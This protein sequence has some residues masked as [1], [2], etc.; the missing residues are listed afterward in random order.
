VNSLNGRETADEQRAQVRGLDAPGTAADELRSQVRDLESAATAAAA[1]RRME[2]PLVDPGE[3]AKNRV[4]TLLVDYQTRL[5]YGHDTIG[6]QARLAEAISVMTEDDQAKARERGKEIRK[7]PAAERKPLWPDHVNRDDLAATVRAYAALAPVV[8]SR[9]LS[10]E[11]T[12]VDAT[13]AEAQKD[14]ATAM[15]AQIDRAIKSGKGLHDLE[16]DQLRA[17]IVDIEAG[18]TAVPDLLLADD[19]SAAVIDRERSDEIAR[20]SARYHRHELEEILRGAGAPTGVARHVREDISRVVTE[21]TQLAAGRTNLRDY[22][23][24]GAD[25][26]LL[27]ALTV[28]GV[29]E[30]VRNQ[31]RNKLTEARD[32]CASTGQQAHWI[33]DRWAGRREKVAV[34]RNPGPPAY[35]SPEYRALQEHNLRQAGLDEDEVRQCLAAEKGRA[36]PPEAAVNPPAPEQKV[37]LTTPGAGVQQTH[38]RGPDRD[39]GLGC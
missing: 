30:P 13:W 39:T 22:E 37:R 17:V 6:V 19:R 3:E 1:L 35:D 7:N 15:R 36:K 16:R 11:G 33:Q 2:S 5:R 29:P 24:T 18:K 34:D 25:E 26:R 31:V 12:D 4:D 9:A 21:H 8:E 38:H 28:H 20:D 10:G 23:A 27:S 32:N 14:R